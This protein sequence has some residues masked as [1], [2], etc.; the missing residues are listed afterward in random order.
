MAV[1][2]VADSATSVT[3]LAANG[4]RKSAEVYNDSSATLYLLCADDTASATSYT[5]KMIPGAFFVVPF[6]YTGILKGVWSSAP[7]GYARVTED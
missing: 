7:G 5:A 3:I 2:T 6:G 4:S 1:T